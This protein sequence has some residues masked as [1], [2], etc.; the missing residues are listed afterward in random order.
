MFPRNS[1][2]FQG[3]SKLFA[4]FSKHFQE[5]SLAVF[6]EING[7]AAAPGDFAF[8]EPRRANCPMARC[9]FVL[10]AAPSAAKGRRSR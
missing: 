8:F 10:L 6:N 1:K 4:N 9:A 2:L 7:L 5:N 3:N